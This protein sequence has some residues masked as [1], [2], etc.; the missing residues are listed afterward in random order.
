MQ[1]TLITDSLIGRLDPYNKVTLRG[2][3]AEG[4]P[5]KIMGMDITQ[6]LRLLRATEYTPE[7]F[8][9]A[10]LKVTGRTPADAADAEAHLQRMVVSLNIR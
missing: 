10:Y 8:K 2:F 1:N 5:T 4:R 7:S 3:D 6:A 9:R